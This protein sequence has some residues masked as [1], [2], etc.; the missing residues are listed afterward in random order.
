MK[1]NYE[2]KIV[3]KVLVEDKDNAIEYIDNFLY[4]LSDMV[5]STD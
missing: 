2:V 3:L 1:R 5:Y 4:G